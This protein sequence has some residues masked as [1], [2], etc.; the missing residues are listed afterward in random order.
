MNIAAITNSI[1]FITA[2]FP[3]A[4]SVARLKTTKYETAPIAASGIPRIVEYGLLNTSEHPLM[5][6][7]RTLRPERCSTVR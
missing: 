7:Q 4:A 2:R 5:T 3:N 1:N 6:V